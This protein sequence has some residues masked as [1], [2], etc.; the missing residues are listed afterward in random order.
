MVTKN[1]D[2]VVSKTISGPI[3]TWEAVGGEAEI[4]GCSFSEAT[5]RLLK[6]AIAVR[7]DARNSSGGL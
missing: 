3:S 7:T 2:I 5:I 6:I 1:R 4:M